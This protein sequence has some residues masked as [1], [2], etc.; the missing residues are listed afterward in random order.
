M[1]KTLREQK[2]ITLVAL[3]ITIIVLLILA[4]VSI[5]LIMNSGIISK[6]KTAVDKYSQEEIEE[7]IKLAYSEW[8]MAKYSGE[9]NQTAAE[10]M[11]TKLIEV[12]GDNALKVEETE[13][14][15][16]TVTLTGGK[17]YTYTAATGAVAKVKT[18]ADLPAATPGIANNSENTKYTSN[19]KTAVI[20]KG[21]AISSVS[22]EQSINT[23]LVIKEVSNDENAKVNEWVWIP[24]DSTEFGKMFGAVSGSD[25][26][27]NGT[28]VVTSHMSKSRKDVKSD[29]TRGVPSSTRYREPGV[30]NND[31]Y[32]KNVTNLSAAGLGSNIGEA[33]AILKDD[34]IS[35]MNSVK[36][37]G[38]FYIGRYELSS[39]G[40]KKGEEPLTN[41]N[42]YN[43][44]A[45]CKASSLG[46]ESVVPRMIWGCQWDAV[47]DFIHT[48]GEQTVITNS[49]TYGNYNNSQSPAN[50]TGS[51]SKQ[52]TGFSDYW[53]ANNIYDIAGNC[54][55]WTQEAYSTGYRAGRGG[56]YSLLGDN[57]AVA[58]RIYD[59]PTST[60][61]SVSSRPTLY[62][63]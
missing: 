16:F 62:I 17:Q 26:V 61:C 13:A 10:F 48:S 31:S 25:A 19:G 6:S 23:G 14:G 43:L 42:W 5:S 29:I 58:Y 47:C 34:Y 20:P 30:L 38:G 12:L 57:N 44:Y 59:S 54:W 9:T 7:Q 18:V 33:A 41:T 28:E 63:Q 36:K 35:M 22:T 1:R 8:Q 3:I 39:A 27:M 24:V 4:M 52:V 60:D 49:R 51:G 21:Y 56:S 46:S 45:A 40:T 37:Y 53:K 55:E 32:D 11:Q 2:A 50:V 15:V